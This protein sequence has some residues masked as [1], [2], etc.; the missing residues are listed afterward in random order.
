M[1]DRPILTI[2]IP[3]FNG[4]KN[5]KLTLK[6]IFD[7]NGLGDEFE[8]LVS[9]NASTDK[10]LGIIKEYE[11]RYPSHLRVNKNITNIGYDRNIDLLVQQSNG[12]YVWFVGCGEV[13]APGSIANILGYLREDSF[14]TIVLNFDVFEE[15]TKKVEIELSYSDCHARI[16]ADRND[17]SFPR[18]CSAVSANI[19]SRDKWLAVSV[20]ALKEVGWCHIERMLDMIASQ[21]FEKS[22]FIPDKSFT[23]Y[24]DA[25]GWWTKNNSYEFLLKHISIIRSLGDRG[26]ASE[27]VSKLDHKLSK[28]ALL[29]AVL[30][31]KSN[32]LRLSLDVFCKFKIMFGNKAFF[33][34]AVIP[35]MIAPQFVARVILNLKQWID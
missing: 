23:L 29:L 8:V 10:T 16:T 35:A 34:F 15:A 3:V 31:A 7:G 1:P 12:I 32:G 18:Y 24:R 5:L 22:L 33:W 28:Y 27:L 17:F 20:N 2:A 14:D 4:Q 26:F 19:V 13:I 21:N 11:D 25:D 6:S 9:D 30:Q